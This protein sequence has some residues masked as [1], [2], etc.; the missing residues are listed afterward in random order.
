MCFDQI[1]RWSQ[2]LFSKI[3]FKKF[4]LVPILHKSI[5]L[6]IKLIYFKCLGYRQRE[7]WPASRRTS[8]YSGNSDE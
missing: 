3:L 4:N 2:Y 6:E 8:A 5:S 1:C 7:N